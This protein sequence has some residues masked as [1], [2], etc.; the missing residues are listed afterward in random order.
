[1]DGPLHILLIDDNPADRA[2]ALAE[3]QLALPGC[4]ITEATSAVGLAAALDCGGFDLA[5]TEYRLG[6][7]D[8][9]AVLRAIHERAPERPVIMLTGGGSEAVAAAGMREGLAD[10]LI[11]T[12]EHYR[13]LPAAVCATLKRAR[14]RALAREAQ[15]AAERAAERSARLQEVTAA[16]ADAFSPAEVSRVIAECGIVALGAHTGYVALLADD[17]RTLEIAGAAG[18]PS[19]VLSHWSSFTLD[20][21]VLLGEVM[22][23]TRLVVMPSR[24]EW[25]RNYPRFAGGWQLTADAAWVGVPMLLEGRPI[26]AFGLGW[27]EPR[28]FDEA[29]RSFMLTLAQQGAQA[30]DR[31]HL[32]DAE[33]RLRA[34]AEEAQQRAAFL[35]Q[36]TNAL[37]S[38]LDYQATLDN[39]AHLAVPQLADW[40]AITALD[41]RTPR[42]MALAC[43]DEA[44]AEA[45][46][47]LV[48]NHPLNPN[49]AFGVPK[50]LRD[51]KSEFHPNF[52]QLLL[53]EQQRGDERAA[54]L[55]RL[56]SRSYICVP[57]LVQ[58]RM[59]GTISFATTHSGRRYSYD[60]LV[61]AEELAARCALAIENARLYQ[62]AREAVRARS[63]ML[64]AVTHDLKNPLGVIKGYTQQ[65]QR[66]LARLNLPAAACL[67]DN[68]SKIDAAATKMNKLL[69]DLLD[70]ARLQADQQLDLNLG[71]LNLTTLTQ[72]VVAEI[73]S[74]AP[75]HQI[76]VK[77]KAAKLS[78]IWDAGRLERVLQNLLGNALKYSPGGGAVVVTLAREQSAD[79]AWAVL[80]V[81]DRGIGIPADDLPRIFERF[82]RARNVVGQFKGSGIGLSS[83]RQIVEQH[84]GTI[85]AAS[86]EG[87]GTVFTVRLPLTTPA[88]GR[89]G[90]GNP[91]RKP[92]P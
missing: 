90:E 28:I 7:C 45:L 15:R 43:A 79:G 77:V 58:E 66:R 20:T 18:L 32:Y 1:M 87:A 67:D 53:E 9:L 54:L 73:Q 80:R 74:T 10:Y 29:E 41:G 78:G 31:A 24:E 52:D 60:D 33:R 71:P 17:G 16:L 62:E 86:E 84:G 35:A 40:C 44:E 48:R 55:L 89:K 11:K 65:I 26:G 91:P 22:R 81:E 64:S 2:R 42:L 50:V 39:V 83:A 38:T 72:Q 19:E 76:R 92:Q 82:Q 4:T 56:H 61:L 75:Q 34:F 6:W 5:I 12:P 14:E 49:A 27:S 85:T 13:A 3:L 21:P 47:E 68:L 59:L 36:A 88:K 70:T 57:L 69:N 37:V 63:E 51:G 8:G 30:I 25:D 46:H 23:S